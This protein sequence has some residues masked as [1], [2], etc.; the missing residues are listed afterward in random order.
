MGILLEKIKRNKRKIK[1]VRKKISGTKAVPRLSFTQTNKNLYIQAI[2]DSKGKTL[3]GLS[4]L[5]KKL[6]LKDGSRKN[7][8]T[9]ELIAEKM[10]E[11]LQAIKIKQVVFDRRTKKYHGIV[12]VFAEKLRK[13]EIKI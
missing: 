8:K 5:D 13:K 1:R 11:K 7:I 2:D 10:A 3:A 9:A 12:K 6:N 4:T